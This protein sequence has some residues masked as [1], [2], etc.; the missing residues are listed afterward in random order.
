M[1]VAGAR[2]FFGCTPTHLLGAPPFRVHT[3][4]Y[5]WEQVKVFP[6]GYKSKLYPCGNT[7]NCSHTPVKDPHKKKRKKKRA[8]RKAQKRKR[9]ARKR[10]TQRAPRKILNAKPTRLPK[11]KPQSTKRKVLTY[12]MKRVFTRD[13]NYAVRQKGCA[14]RIAPIGTLSQNGYGEDMERRKGTVPRPSGGTPLKRCSDPGRT[15]IVLRDLLEKVPEEIL[16]D[17]AS[18]VELGELYPTS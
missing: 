8:K 2:H 13:R 4:A 10:K 18:L 11:N 17:L 15:P 1:N 9:N 7:L 5:V 6:H 12:K 14:E 16:S 3:N